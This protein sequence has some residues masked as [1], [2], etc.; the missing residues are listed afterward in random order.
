MTDYTPEIEDEERRQFLRVLGL[1]SAAAVGSE[2]TLD[3][4]RGE[5]RGNSADE[6]S[7]MG[8]AIRGDVTGELDADLLAGGLA[9][10]STQMDRLQEVRAAG[11]PDQ[12]ERLYRELVAPA[13][14]I[15]DHLEAVGFYGSVESH[16]PAFTE[17]HIESVARELIRT[18]LLTNTLSDLGFSEQEKTALVMNVVNNTGRLALWM[19]TKDIPEGV[20]FDVEHVAPLHHR[21]AEGS[22]LWVDDMDTHLWQNEILLTDD[23]LDTAMWDIKT[24]L[25]GFHL[26]GTAAHGVTDGSLTDSQ[27]T[28][29]LTTGT[30]AMIVGQEDL[31][32]DAFR[33]TDEM[34]APHSWEIEG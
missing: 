33:I 26:L 3:G 32:N 22:L 15:N 20:E 5:L 7:S 25:G 16:L 6:L 10:L 19:P 1:T 18:E 24:M 34:R 8:H 12:H 14:T 11:I 27:L 13:W 21:A 17:D 9:G 31:T 23:I 28:A 2:L 4:I 29:A 30:A